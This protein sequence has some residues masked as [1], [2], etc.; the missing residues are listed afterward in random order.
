MGFDHLGFPALARALAAVRE[1]RPGANPLR[2][3]TLGY[4]DIVMTEEQLEHAVGP[5]A[6]AA[7]ENRRDAEALKHAHQ[8]G[9]ISRVPTMESFFA[10]LD[11]RVTAFD[12]RAHVGTEIVWDFSR[13]LPSEHHAR[14]DAVIDGGT[15]EHVFDVA[16][17]LRNCARMTALHGCVIHT[18]PLAMGNHAFYAFNPT[19]MHDF[20]TA[21]GFRLLSL[22]AF[23]MVLDGHR[24]QY[25]P[26]PIAPTERFSLAVNMEAILV[27]VVQRIRLVQDLVDPI[28]TVYKV[29]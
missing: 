20:Y 2:V 28:Q 9:A 10:A 24:R 29:A 5:A 15:C 19:L 4:L 3:A 6:A 12:F 17:A 11:C 23:G 7:L 27:T 18:N 13:P 16:T 21:N 26:I 14:F 1:H 8:A 25:V 22:D